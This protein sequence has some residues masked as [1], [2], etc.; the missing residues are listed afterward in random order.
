MAK[1]GNSQQ[2]HTLTAITQVQALPAAKWTV[3]IS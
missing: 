1:A 3:A 2:L